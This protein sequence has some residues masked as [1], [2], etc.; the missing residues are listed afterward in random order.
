MK[1]ISIFSQDLIKKSLHFKIFKNKIK[2][3]DLV[4]IES[5][6]YAQVVFDDV[7]ECYSENQHLECLFNLNELLKADSSDWIGIY[8]V[9]FTNYKDFV[10][11]QQ[12][13]FDSISDFKAKIV[14][15]GF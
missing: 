1:L 6:D 8:K 11:K 13:D 9:G 15:Q 4:M 12:I 14:F 10:C 7:K 2:M 5:K 3:E